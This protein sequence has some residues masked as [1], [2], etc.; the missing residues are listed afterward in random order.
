LGD[1]HFTYLLHAFLA[2]F[3]FFKQLAFPSDVTTVA[4]GNNV[5]AQRLYRF[6]RDEGYP[7]KEQWFP[8]LNAED[9]AAAAPLLNR[10]LE[11]QTAAPA[12]KSDGDVFKVLDVLAFD[13]GIRGIFS[14]WAAT[15]TYF[16]NCM[17]LK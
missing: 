7:V 16:A 14:D 8:T 6:A 11:G 15:V 10:P 4:L 1:F 17:G 5:L 12:I 3:L 13:V 2:F 9:R